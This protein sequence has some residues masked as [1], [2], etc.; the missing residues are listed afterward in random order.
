MRQITKAAVAAF[1]QGFDYKSGNTQVRDNALYLHGNKI[2]ELRDGELWITNAGWSSNTTKE[3]L[4]ALPNVHI[5]QKNF[6]WYLNGY[7]WNGRWIK[8]ER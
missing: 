1:L 6:V 5:Q 7:V 8:V 3:R 2:A 4:N